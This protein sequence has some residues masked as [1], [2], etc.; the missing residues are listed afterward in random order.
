M[1][2]LALLTSFHRQGRLRWVGYITGGH[3]RKESA[4][5]ALAQSDPTRNE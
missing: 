1:G 5:V 3:Y 2:S 4:V